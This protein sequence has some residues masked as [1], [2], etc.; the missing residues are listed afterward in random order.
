MPWPPAC[1]AAHGDP[2]PRPFPSLC[3]SRPPRALSGCK[4]PA[5]RD[6]LRRCG[7]RGWWAGLL[8]PSACCFCG[9]P[10]HAALQGGTRSAGATFGAS[11]CSRRPI[12]QGQPPRGGI[13]SIEAS[14][15]APCSG[16]PSAICHPRLHSVRPAH[17]A[18]PPASRSAAGILGK[19]FV[20]VVAAID[21]GGLAPAAFGR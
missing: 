20:L 11:I 3:C 18:V 9:S 19:R 15:P 17:R 7:V 1:C 10:P 16:W 2:E 12:P 5:T 4:H 14:R 13:R 6:D 8:A 21:T